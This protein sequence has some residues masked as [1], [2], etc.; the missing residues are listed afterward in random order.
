MLEDQKRL[1]GG[2]RLEAMAA[3]DAAAWRDVAFRRL[4]IGVRAARLQAAHQGRLEADKA[5]GHDLFLA[6]WRIIAIAIAGIGDGGDPKAA[7]R[8]SGGQRHGWHRSGRSKESKKCSITLP[9]C[10]PRSPASPSVPPGMARS[11][12]P[13]WPPGVMVVGGRRWLVWARFPFPISLPS[14][15]SWSWPGCSPAFSCTWRRVASY[16]ARALG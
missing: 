16:R 13:G 7:R 4:T 12:R 5:D 6:K 15:P 11:L 2:D 1:A 10:W 8:Q 9:C 14:S 3:G